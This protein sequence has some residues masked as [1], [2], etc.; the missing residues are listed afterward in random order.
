MIVPPVSAVVFDFDGVLA[1]T[2]DL[3]CA[4]FQQVARDRGLALSRDD[5]YGRFLGLPDH[6]CIAALC[7]EAGQPLPPAELERLVTRKRLHFAE[8]SRT[9]DLYPGVGAALERLHAHFALAIA[10]GAA[11]DE[12]EA[13]LRRA[14]V[15]SLFAAVVAAEDVAAG[16]PAP[17]P[18]L[19]ALERL[20][21]RLPRPLA[22]G[23]CVV[24]EDSPAGIAAARAAGMRCIAV[25]TSHGRAALAAADAVL[26]GVAHLRAEDLGR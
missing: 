3:H 25:T 18:F 13:V 15:R 11:R 26:D 10:S 21:R 14:R 6:D 7:A 9:T 24:V 16:K 2:E 4:A 20:N 5:Y 1:D 23:E 17:D 22:S 19:R 8:L 12:I